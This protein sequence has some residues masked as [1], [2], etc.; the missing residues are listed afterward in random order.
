M[1]VQYT[2]LGFQ[3]SEHESRQITA[4]PSNKF[5]VPIRSLNRSHRRRRHRRRHRRWF[6]SH[7]WPLKLTSKKK[8]WKSAQ[9]K[10]SFKT[11]AN[12]FNPPSLTL[13]VSCLSCFNLV[14]LSA[15]LTKLGRWQNQLRT[16][17]KMPVL[18]IN[19]L[20]GLT[21]WKIIA[22]ENCEPNWKYKNIQ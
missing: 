10:F 20:V 8:S 3:P 9:L 6:F 19:Y 2:A 17:F 1:F 16:P 15:L 7:C 18:T 22:A 12:F 4:R 13:S 11:L 14:C 21:L 5:W